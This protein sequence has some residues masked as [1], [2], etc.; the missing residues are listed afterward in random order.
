LSLFSQKSQ[1]LPFKSGEKISY[2]VYY[3]LAWIW[4]DAAVVEF[5]VSDS[6][7]NKQDLFYFESIGYSRQSY[8]WIFKVRD[9]FTSFASKTDLAPVNY[10]RKTQEGSH[11]VNNRYYFSHDIKQIRTFIDDSDKGGIQDTISF[12]SPVFD[13][14]TASY[15]FRAVNFSNMKEGQ[16]IAINTV[17]DNEL[18]KLQIEFLG[19]EIIEHKNKKSYSTFKF[20]TKAIEGSVFDKNSEIVVWISK[21]KNHIP[22]KVESEILVGSV[23][24]YLSEVRSP[25]DSSSVIIKDFLLK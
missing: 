16:T 25:K 18:V 8:D 20:K 11:K 5:S 9:R 24:A 6:L 3:N 14:L 4:V 15:F 19:E 22:L 21:D 17:M 1:A 10:C 23:I 2:T 13:V 7:Y 12:S